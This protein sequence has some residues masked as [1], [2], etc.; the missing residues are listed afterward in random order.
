M[1]GLEDVQRARVAA[2]GYRV[3]QDQRVPL[4]EQVVG[5]VHAPDAVVDRHA[6]SA[7]SLRDLGVPDHLGAEPVVPEEDVAD[8]GNQDASRHR[9]D[10]AATCAAS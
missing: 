10:R 5:Q 1:I 9:A 3:D 2:V 6:R 4:V 8:S 7:S